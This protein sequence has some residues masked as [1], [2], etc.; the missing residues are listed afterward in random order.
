MYAEDHI[1]REEELLKAAES[2]AC[3]WKRAEIHRQIERESKRHS[4][5][6]GESFRDYRVRRFARHIFADVDA[7]LSEQDK[8]GTFPIK[9]FCACPSETRWRFC[10]EAL[11]DERV[12]RKMKAHIVAWM[13]N[14]PEMNAPGRIQDVRRVLDEDDSRILF[15]FPSRLARIEYCRRR[16]LDW[17]SVA[18]M[19]GGEANPAAYT[20]CLWWEERYGVTKEEETELNRDDGPRFALVMSLS[21]HHICKTLLLGLIHNGRWGILRFLYQTFEECWK[22]LPAERILSLLCTNGE[23]ATEGNGLQRVVNRGCYDFAEYVIT[24]RPNAIANARDAFG[25]SLLW[26]TFYRSQT[27]HRTGKIYPKIEKMLVDHGCDPFEMTI[28]GVSWAEVA[29]AQYED[30]ISEHDRDI[31]AMYITGSG[32]WFSEIVRDDRMGK[33]V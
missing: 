16:M 4:V 20:S 24:R 21:G 27:S 19:S 3:A 8:T 23:I 2:K 11:R 14:L 1:A 30:H 17:R 29:R 13:M 28:L 18:V 26:Q 33:D 5:V 32:D 6:H 25:C 7:F 12:S 31:D 10:A 22:I 15:L 9:Y